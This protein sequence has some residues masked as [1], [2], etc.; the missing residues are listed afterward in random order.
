[1]LSISQAKDIRSVV[2]ELRSRG[3]SRLDI[4]LVLRTLRPDARF[5][6]LLSPNELDLINRV[7]AMKV[8]LYRMRNMVYDLEKKVRKRHEMIVGIYEELLRSAKE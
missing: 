2:N 4:Y 8:E 5:E 1:M 6:Y 3:L 7:N